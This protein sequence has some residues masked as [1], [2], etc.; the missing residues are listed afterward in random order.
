MRLELSCQGANLHRWQGGPV[1]DRDSSVQVRR[2]K[3][4]ELVAEVRAIPPASLGTLSR[5]PAPAPAGTGE[6]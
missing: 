6:G 4:S 1:C 5:R 2:V 3:H